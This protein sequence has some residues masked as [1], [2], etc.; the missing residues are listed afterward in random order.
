MSWSDSKLPAATRRGLLGAGLA[1]LAVAASEA[2]GA[3]APAPITPPKNAPWDDGD[4]PAT[5]HSSRQMADAARAFLA[6]LTADQCKKAVFADLGNAA[7][8]QW[9]NFP[10]GFVPRPGVAIGDMTNVQR[11]AL[12]ALLRASA[13][14]QGYHKFS[15]AIRADGILHDL[16]GEALFSSANYYA[17]V[18]GSPDSTNWAWML[19]GHHMAA[20]F[21]VAG[22]NRTAFTPMFTGSQPLQIMKGL[23]AGWQTLPHDAGRAGDLLA[24]LTDMQRKI[25]VIG[26]NAPG[27][28]L[29]G[30]GRQKSLGSYT[31]IASHELDADQQRLL[32]RL[33]REF[34]E[35]AN[36]DAAEAQLALVKQGWHDTHFAWLGPVPSPDARYYFRVH[37]P[38]ILIEYD[39]Q[40]PL[41]SGGGHIHAITR[42]PSNDYGVDWL[43][44]HYREVEPHGGPPT[45]NFPARPADFHPL[46]PGPSAAPSSRP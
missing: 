33:V 7:R 30:P 19:T 18:Y 14:S 23:E 31:G 2:A 22:E 17:S 41:T 43:G 6:T 1:A 40:E 42:D 27:D 34:V 11:I 10:A 12:H 5:A 4:I 29:V 24:S 35:N 8:T 38:R 32:W 16:Q 45:G 39:V 36:V 37:G 46:G 21:T 25:A 13:S 28:V 20:I 44:L 9:S 3:K 26:A 15:G